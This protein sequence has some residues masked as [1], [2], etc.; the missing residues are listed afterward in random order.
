[1]DGIFFSACI[2][3]QKHSIVLLT[4]NRCLVYHNV[5]ILATNMVKQNHAKTTLIDQ[6][7]A[8]TKNLFSERCWFV[9]FCLLFFL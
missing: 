2:S 7:D 6:T 4:A 8:I 1:M 9:Y 5:V 3:K